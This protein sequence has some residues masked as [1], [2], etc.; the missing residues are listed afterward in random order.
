MLPG[1]H[2]PAHHAK[3]VPRPIH[4]LTSHSAV[5]RAG[6][7]LGRTGREGRA[8]VHGDGGDAEGVDRGRARR[9]W[10]GVG[11]AA[12]AGEVEGVRGHARRGGGEEV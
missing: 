11:L 12:G 2:I 5:G 3:Q 8:V 9:A 7:Q 1:A 4:A 10:R 6:L